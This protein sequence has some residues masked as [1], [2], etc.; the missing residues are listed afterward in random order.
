MSVF[1]AGQFTNLTTTS[2]NVFWAV[3]IGMFVGAA[4][5][6]SLNTLP[7]LVKKPVLSVVQK[8]MTGAATNIIAGLGSG[9]MSTALPVILF[10][11]AIWGA[12]FIGKI[13]WSWNCSVCNDGYH[14]N[15]TSRLMHLVPLRIMPVELL[16]WGAS[17]RSTWE[18]WYPWLSR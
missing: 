7:D 5:S 4:I 2:M 11:G 1:N 18:N 10:A 8:S 17:F 12:L 3:V 16:K 14:C 6:I 9:M 13:L 15:A